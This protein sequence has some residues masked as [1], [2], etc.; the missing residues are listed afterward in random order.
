MHEETPYHVTTVDADTCTC[1]C[2]AQSC[3]AGKAQLGLVDAP[4][5]TLRQLKGMDT[6]FVRPG[7]SGVL[8]AHNNRVHMS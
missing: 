1:M 8:K 7:T 4:D 6:L 5:F 3:S 2:T